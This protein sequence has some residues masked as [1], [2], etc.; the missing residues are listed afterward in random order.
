MDMSDE[1]EEFE[2]TEDQIDA[3]MTA[4]DPVE[5]VVPGESQYVDSLYVVTGVPV[6]TNGG[7]LPGR[8][9]ASVVSSVQVAVPVGQTAA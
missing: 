3:M 9:F 4:G 7:A 1:F 6:T 2:T 8:S 5:L